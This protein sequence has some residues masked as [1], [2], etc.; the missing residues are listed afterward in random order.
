MVVYGRKNGC[1]FVPDQIGPLKGMLGLGRPEGHGVKAGFR[2][3][4]VSSSFLKWL[5]GVCRHRLR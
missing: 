2:S 3:S 1:D 4:R 5:E